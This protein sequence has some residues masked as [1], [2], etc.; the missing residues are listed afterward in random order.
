MLKMPYQLN[1]TRKWRSKNFDHLV[2]QEL[3][4]KILKNGLYLGQFFPV[5]LFAGQRGCGKTSMARI[6]AAALNCSQ[7]EAF[8]KNP[9]KS[10]VPCLTCPSCSAMAQGRHPDFFEIDAASHTGVD[11]IRTIIEAS[12]LLPLMSPKKIYVIDEA[13][14]L[15]KASCNALLKILEEPPQSVIFMLATTD[16][17]KIIETV[18]SRCFQLLFKP[19]A[20]DLLVNH[21]AHICQQEAIS[22]EDNALELIVHETHGSAR[23]AI[24]LLE[25]VRF[26]SKTVNKNA[27]VL[28]LGHVHDEHLI[29]IMMNMVQQNPADLIKFL[30]SIQFETFSADFIWNRLIELIREALLIKYDIKPT[31]FAAHA[32][33][34]H[35]LAQ[36]CP[37]SLFHT[38]LETLYLNEM[39]FLKTSSKHALLEIILLQLCQKKTDNESKTVIL[40]NH[41]QPSNKISVEPS[42]PVLAPKTSVVLNHE[43]NITTSKTHAMAEWTAFQQCI[44]QLRACPYT[45]TF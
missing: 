16:P 19:I 4:I 44:E 28:V 32:D 21:L 10:P 8:Q 35:A 14:M 45:I 38:F 3:T 37:V 22:Y 11:T 18:R 7:L 30:H 26:S 12:Q 25:Q 27:V 41:V 20:T 24:N 1:L 36:A 5:Y 13:H 43:G 42:K 23:D 31:T 33:Q 17:L 15:S 9:K 29:T 40:T 34:L 2:G 39:S 6:F